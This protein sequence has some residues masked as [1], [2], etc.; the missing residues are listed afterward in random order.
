VTAF[1]LR[2]RRGV[3]SGKK[4]IIKVPAHVQLLPTLRGA[5]AQ[6]AISSPMKAND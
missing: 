6:P 1:N 2:K 5:G 3:K 4:L